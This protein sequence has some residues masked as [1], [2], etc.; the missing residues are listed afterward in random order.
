MS[1]VYELRKQT[2]ELYWELYR[3]IV[4]DNLKT[5][6]RSKLNAFVDLIDDE[7]I[8]EAS[9][10]LEKSI[11]GGMAGALEW[12]RELDAQVKQELRSELAELA[13]LC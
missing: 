13:M 11:N 1:E 10:G 6:M 5:G 2:K 12:M 4:P 3:S 8:L 9:Q 7:G